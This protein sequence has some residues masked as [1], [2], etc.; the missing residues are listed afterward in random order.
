MGQPARLF[1]IHR[2]V[3]QLDLKLYRLTQDQFLAAM[4]DWWEFEPKGDVVRDWTV[5]V[6]SPQNETDYSAIDLAENRGA[7]AP[8]I[9][10]LDLRAPGVEY[11]RWGHR[12]VLVDE[13]LAGAQV[14]LALQPQS[15]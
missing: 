1:V 14:Q 7:L 3:E 2:N 9:Y 8:G 6:P 11:D 12:H 13:I 15:C 10:L 5:D 4:D